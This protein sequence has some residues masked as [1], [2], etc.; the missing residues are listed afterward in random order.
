MSSSL[1]LGSRL[2]LPQAFERLRPDIERRLP[3]LRPPA[4]AWAA[5]AENGLPVSGPD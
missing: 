2:K 4:P 5:P 1:S 3:P